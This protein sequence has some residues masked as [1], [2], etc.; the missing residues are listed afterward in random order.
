MSFSHF[1]E[2]PFWVTARARERRMPRGRWLWSAL[3]WPLLLV[4]GPA[5][6]MALATGWDLGSIQGTLVLTAFA[7][8]VA[9]AIRAAGATALAVV[10]E[11]QQGTLMTLALTR[12]DS[13]EYADGVALASCYPVLR[14]ILVGLPVAC[15][16]GILAG[17]NPL[18][19]LMLAPICLM[20]TLV[21]SYHGL[22]ISA[23]SRTAQQATS[24]VWGQTLGFFFASPFLFICGGFV[25]YPLWLLHPYAAMCLALWGAD[26]PGPNGGGLLI[27]R[28]YALLF[29]PLYVALLRWVRRRAI[30][31][32]ERI[33]L[34]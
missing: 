10:S 22:W 5:A 9:A 28:W 7:V 11:R 26:G 6:F 18:G 17:A 23:T 15:G 30:A 4:A 25:A 12:L 34:T 2:S 32:L 27:L 3:G 31:A 19:V 1:R 14:A 13:A 33:P 20:V 8:V 24:R 21:F 16:L 29:A